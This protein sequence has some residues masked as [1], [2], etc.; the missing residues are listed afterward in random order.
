MYCPLLQS[1]RHSGCQLSRGYP[2]LHGQARVKEQAASKKQLLM[3]RSIC[4]G[5]GILLVL[6]L[7]GVLVASSKGS[8]PA[9]PGEAG[10]FTN[11]V[12]R[13]IARAREPFS[14]AAH[15]GPA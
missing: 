4:V 1:D 12:S 6:V 8:N 10:P 11:I 5:G 9:R 14:C 2:A 13:P 15:N 7:V 3:K